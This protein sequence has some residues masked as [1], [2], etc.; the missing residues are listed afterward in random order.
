[1]QLLVSKLLLGFSK[2][3]RKGFEKAKFSNFKKKMVLV[4]TI[5]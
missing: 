3:K 4:R 5:W 1:M 2:K